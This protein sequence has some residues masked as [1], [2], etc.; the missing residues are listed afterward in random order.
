M[1]NLLLSLLVAAA[2]VKI[3]AILYNRLSMICYT[4]LSNVIVTIAQ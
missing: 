3:S 4:R 1:L 2:H